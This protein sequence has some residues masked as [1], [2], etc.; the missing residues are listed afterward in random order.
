[1]KA[2]ASLA[3]IFLSL[4]SCLMLRAQSGGSSAGTAAPPKVLLLVHQ[5]YQPGKVSARQKLAAMSHACD[6][7]A[8]PNSWIDLESVTGPS[9]ALFFDPFDSF[10]QM[11]KAG[12]EWSR[13]F[14]THPDIARLQDEIRALVA[15]ERTVIAV[16]RDDVGYRADSIDLSK[17]RILRVLEV[18]LHPGRES[19]FVEAFKMLAAAYQKINSDTPWVVYQVNAGMPSPA[20]LVFV[21]MKALRQNDDLL[22]RGQSLQGAEGEAGVE[23]MQEVAREAYNST[24]SNLYAISPEMSHVSREFAAGDPVFWSPKPTAVAGGKHTGN[25]PAASTGGSN[26]DKKPN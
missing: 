6:H 12:A 9:E 2:R 1:M 11:D 20:F 14:S 16:R 10:E 7:L 26:R 17:A 25:K 22:A 18:R 24:E 23:R 5:T 3:I 8:V 21:P 4:L 15:G 13:I 19:D